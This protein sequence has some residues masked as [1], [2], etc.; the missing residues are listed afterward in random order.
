MRRLG[1]IYANSR[2]RDLMGLEA[3][4]LEGKTCS[5]VGLPDDLSW[6]VKDTLSKGRGIDREV[7][8]QIF[9]SIQNLHI[10][11]AY[12]KTAS[13]PEI[14]AT[15]RDITTIRR[16]ER[17]I[18]DLAQRLTY[19]VNNT[20]L[21]VMEWTP[22]GTCLTWNDEAEDMFGWSRRELKKTAYPRW[23]WC[24]TTIGRPSV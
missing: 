19:H 14:I 18:H 10:R 13:R 12:D 8:L 6:I 22:D 7:E 15:V 3:D 2:I 17:H 1:S 11:T 23:L 5:E 20:P 21:A 9:G 4:W 24:M 16:H